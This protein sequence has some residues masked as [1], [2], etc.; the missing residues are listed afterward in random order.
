[1][2]DKTELPTSITRSMTVTSPHDLQGLLYP[3][4]SGVKRYGRETGQDTTT[5]QWVLQLTWVEK[6]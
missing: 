6:K 4:Y 1:M 2:S 5:G 3:L